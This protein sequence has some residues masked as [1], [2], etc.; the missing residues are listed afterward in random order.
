[1]SFVTSI[2]ATKYQSS[3]FAAYNHLIYFASVGLGFSSKDIPVR[4]F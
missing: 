2:A 1:M 3:S 4:F